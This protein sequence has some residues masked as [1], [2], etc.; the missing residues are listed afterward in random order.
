MTVGVETT[1]TENDEDKL[2]TAGNILPDDSDSY[3]TISVTNPDA[4]LAA[5]KSLIPI[6][7]S[8][9]NLV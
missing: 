6:F 4:R 9:V 1:E 8:A 2:V 3:I 7:M 5:I